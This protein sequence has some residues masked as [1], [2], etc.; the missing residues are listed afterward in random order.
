M[1][2]TPLSDHPLAIAFH[3]LTPDEVL[4]A[5]ESA[6]GRCTGRALALNSYENRVYQFEMEDDSFVVG[7]FYR[8]GRWS[9][10]A[11]AD[12]HRFLAELTEEG[13]P[14]AAPL[15][16]AGGGTIGSVQ[17]ILYAIFPRLRGRTPQELDDPQVR[18][19]GRLLARVHN[20]GAR[21]DATQR[22]RLNP[23]TYGRDNLAFLL[24]HGAIPDE[25]RDVYRATVE[26]LLVRVFDRFAGIPSH[27]IHGDCHLGNIVLADKGPAFLDFDDMVVGPAA[28]DVWMLVPSYDEEGARQRGVLL[29]AYEEL[30]GFDRAWLRLVEPLR[31][32]R[33]VHYST[34]IARRFDDPIFR[35]TFPHFGTVQYWQREIQDLREQIARLDCE[36]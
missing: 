36:R 5:A 21:A 29:D 13:V 24:E 33:F 32:L 4:G 3:R 12:E 8:P 23:S 30:R 16:L 25:A 31:A 22:L 11:I 14:V 7:K 15:P 28:Q 34:W 10:E 2:S 1:T 27:R 26:M 6:G 20:V 35:R 18:T 9:R 17:G 19:L